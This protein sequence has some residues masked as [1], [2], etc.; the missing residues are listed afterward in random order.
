MVDGGLSEVFHLSSELVPVACILGWSVGSQTID[1]HTLRCKGDWPRRFEDF[2][3]ENIEKLQ[4]IM[5]GSRRVRFSADQTPQRVAIE[6]RI[7]SCI[8][9]HDLQGFQRI[10]MSTNKMKSAQMQLFGRKGGLTIPSGSARS[11]NISEPPIAPRCCLYL[12]N[13]GICCEVMASGGYL[14]TAGTKIVINFF[15]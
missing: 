9:R 7:S 13:G 1:S 8:S 14:R 4:D 3:R 15:G 12:Y 5:W 11:I 2:V 6:H 10:R